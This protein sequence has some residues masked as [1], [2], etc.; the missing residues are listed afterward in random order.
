M[1][2]EV[3]TLLRKH[4]FSVCISSL[5]QI[6]KDPTRSYRRYRK[7]CQVPGLLG[8]LLREATPETQIQ[9]V[10]QEGARNTVVAYLNFLCYNQPWLNVLCIGIDRE[11]EKFRSILA[12]RFMLVGLS[13]GTKNVPVDTTCLKLVHK[14]EFIVKV[15]TGMVKQNAGL[16][17]KFEMEKDGKIV[18][19]ALWSYRNPCLDIVGP[20]MEELEIAPEWRD[21]GVE[22]LLLCTMEQKMIQNFQP[23]VAFQLQVNNVD[24]YDASIRRWFTRRGFTDIGRRRSCALC[25]GFAI[26]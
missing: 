20:C 11:R 6:Q 23:L 21:L 2:L 24:D 7:N 1:L 18:C 3:I 25:K 22:T 17:T 19:R 10:Q 5:D 9:V 4:G 16:L 13:H 8:K 14:S 26:I 15:T 12:K